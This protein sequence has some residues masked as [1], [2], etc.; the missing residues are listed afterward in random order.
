MPPSFFNNHNAVRERA[1]SPQMRDQF[2]VFRLQEN[3]YLRQDFGQNSQMW[4]HYTSRIDSEFF[5]K[6]YSELEVIEVF[7]EVFLR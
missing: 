1:L 6:K 3:F 5:A 4:V 7:C 2:V